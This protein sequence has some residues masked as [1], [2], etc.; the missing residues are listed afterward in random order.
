MFTKIK[1]FFILLGYKIKELPLWEKLK[2]IPRKT[3]IILGS[4]VAGAV[5]IS[6][7]VAL[8][9]PL[10]VGGGADGGIFNGGNGGINPSL[11]NPVI[12]SIY[13][14]SLPEKSVFYKNEPADFSGLAIGV[15]GMNISESF[16]YYDE[17]PDEFKFSGFDSSEPTMYQEIT[18]EYKGFTAT[19]TVNIR[20]LSQAKPTLQS[21]YLSPEPKS[22]CRIGKAPSIAGV[23][24]IS[25]YSDG[26]EKTKDLEYSDLQ[27]DYLEKLAVAQIGDTITITVEYG[28][29]GHW[30]ETTFDIKITP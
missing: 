16:V 7:A 10:F 14:S 13:V 29:N 15:N 18:V 21:I 12:E 3:W 19:F 1:T 30:A 28:D 20:E 24:L 4:C 5:A 25:V 8:L 26:K 9:L 11:G 17:N 2:E 23:K 22:T 27:D 6:V